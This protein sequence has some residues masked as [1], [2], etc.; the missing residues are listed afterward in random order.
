MN[1]IDK[2]FNSKEN[3]Y[4]TSAPIIGNTIETR[5]FETKNSENSIRDFLKSNDLELIRKQSE[6]IKLFKEIYDLYND[7][8]EKLND[9]IYEYKNNFDPSIEKY[10][11]DIINNNEKIDNKIITS[12]IET[13]NKISEYDKLTIEQNSE[14]YKFNYIE[15]KNSS[16]SFDKNIIKLD[17]EKYNISRFNNKENKIF[18]INNDIYLKKIVLKSPDINDIVISN[19]NGDHMVVTIKSKEKIYLRNFENNEPKFPFIIKSDIDA[20]G[21]LSILNIKNDII[22]QKLNNYYDEND[23]TSETKLIEENKFV[24]E[25]GEI[26]NEECVDGYFIEFE[27]RDN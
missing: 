19:E 3:N 24:T 20:M 13:S 7:I 6:Y 23:I 17:D 16:L 22:D 12:I 26:S 4:K 5:I 10:N 9:I 2:K 1:D 15:Q 8:D 11:L 14:K 18:K 25:Y 27:D 21:G